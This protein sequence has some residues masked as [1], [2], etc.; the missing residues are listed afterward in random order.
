MYRVTF[1]FA[2][3]G[4]EVYRSDLNVADIMKS[5]ESLLFLKANTNLRVRITTEPDSNAPSIAEINIYAN[6]EGSLSRAETRVFASSFLDAQRQASNVVLQLLS[7]WSFCYDVALE[8]TGYELLE[9]YTEVKKWV[10]GLVGKGRNFVLDNIPAITKLPFKIIFSSYREAL[11]STNAFYQFLCF[12]KVI[13][14]TR[15]IRLKRKDAALSAGQEYRDTPERIPDD[16]KHLNISDP[17]ERDHFQPYMG[18]K[19]G[20]ILDEFR[21]LLRNA[22][23]HLDPTADTLVADNFDDVSKCEGAI[24][25]IKYIAREMLRNEL[26]ADPDYSSATIS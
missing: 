4:K 1:V 7:W 12:Y 18:K 21:E 23:A 19:F 25:V 14:A 16:I 17:M 24:P 6:S 3:P 5:G 13:E 26:Q 8:I 15:K 22:V 2:I 10:F 9:E 20:W 11:N